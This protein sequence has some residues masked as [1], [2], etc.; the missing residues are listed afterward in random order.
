MPEENSYTIVSKLG[1]MV[2]YKHGRIN[3]RDPGEDNWRGPTLLEAYVLGRYVEFEA[4]IARGR[5]DISRMI[6]GD[7]L[8][9]LG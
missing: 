2:Q 8:E 9:K 1:L 7:R 5:K 4:T 6:E 3:V